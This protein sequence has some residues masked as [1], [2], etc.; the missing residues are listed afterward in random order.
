M[1]QQFSPHNED[2]TRFAEHVKGEV[3]DVQDLARLGLCSFCKNDMDLDEARTITAAVALISMVMAAGI[4]INR[5]RRRSMW[6]RPWIQRR[7]GGRGMLNMV[8]KEL[9]VEDREAFRNFMRM[10]EEQFY[11]ILG[12]IRNDIEKQETSMRDS[13]SAE[14]RLSLTLR[15]LA[16]GETYRSLMYSTRTH[17]S[18]ISKI[19]PDMCDIIYRNLKRKYLK[20]PRTCQEW[21]DVALKFGSIWNFPMCLG[22]I[23]GKHIAFRSHS[24]VLLAVADALCRFIYD[25]VGVN[26]RVSDGGVF[27]I[28]RNTLNFPPN[29]KLPNRQA[30]VPY[31]FVADD[32]FPLTPHILKPY[33]NRDL[34]EEKRNFNYRL[35]RARRTV[36]NAFGILSNRFRVFQTK[37]NLS[38]EK[39]ETIV[40]AAVALHN[41]LCEKNG[42]TY[43]AS[44]ED[45]CPL[46]VLPQQAGKRPTQS[47][48]DI[49]KEYTNYFNA[50]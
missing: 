27:P 9:A 18:T 2:Q 50:N 26:G 24:I 37:I 23:D 39:V 29:K 47:A 17:H 12:L 8:H 38:P 16:T 21:E 22:A 10:T 25:D 32:A 13:I 31:V 34:T 14:K 5:R 43:T 40:L 41:F 15:F 36:E 28:A 45:D 6:T 1:A 4:I 19:I 7:E 48:L 35:S 20:V 3:E 44:V 42:A 30:E 49:R 11:E 33:P 46:L